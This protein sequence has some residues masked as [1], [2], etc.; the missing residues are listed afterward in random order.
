MRTWN[1]SEIPSSAAASPQSSVHLVLVSSLAPDFIPVI[2]TPLGYT[3]PR[4]HLVLLKNIMN[5]GA[6]ITLISS[7][8]LSLDNP[9]IHN[10]PLIVSNI[11]M[12]GLSLASRINLLKLSQ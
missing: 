6:N 8:L 9:R 12:I 5:F 1:S 11:V 7:H 3:L 4:V 10:K 2:T